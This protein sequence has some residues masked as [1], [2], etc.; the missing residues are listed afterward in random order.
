MDR[1]RCAIPN[2][3]YYANNGEHGTQEWF[4]EGFDYYAYSREENAFLKK[5][6]PR[7]HA[8]FRGRFGS[9]R[10]PAAA[11]PAPLPTPVAPGGATTPGTGPAP[12]GGGIL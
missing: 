9:A 2:R 11:R 3:T 12:G 8:Y 7:T 10:F 1:C 6:F 4:A 5:C